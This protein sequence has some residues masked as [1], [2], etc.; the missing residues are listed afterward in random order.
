MRLLFRQLGLAIAGKIKGSGILDELAASAEKWRADQGKRQGK[1]LRAEPQSP[2]DRQSK[3]VGRGGQPLDPEHER[4]LERIFRTAG[5]VAWAK[6]ILSDIEAFQLDM[7]GTLADDY[8]G[9]Y[10]AGA[11]A[12]RIQLGVRG[13][14][15]LR[16]PFIL[17]QLEERAN[18]LSGGIADELFDRMKTVVADDFYIGGQSPLQVARGLRDEFDWMGKTRS[19]LIARNETGIVTSGA[20]HQ[21]YEMAGVEGKRWAAF[22]DDR[23]RFSHKNAHGQV[24][25]LELPF[26]LIDEEGE[27]HYLQHPHDPDADISQVANCRC[28]ELPII[29]AAHRYDESSVWDGSVDPDDFEAAEPGA[30]S[31]AGGEE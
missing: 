4:Q 12:A 5:V 23:T 2:P 3:A 7:E 17:D 22:R 6:L 13:A 21:V 19:E 25:P 20:Q 8:A 26:E 16:S 14:F 24:Q 15:N 30:E 10:E 18:M 28:A 29:D 11:R 9:L 31:P 27:V 1:G